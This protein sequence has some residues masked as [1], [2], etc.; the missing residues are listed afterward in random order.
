MLLSGCPGNKEQ[1]QKQRREAS[2]RQAAET[3]ED[4]LPGRF[5]RIIDP[6]S[7][8]TSHLLATFHLLCRQQLNLPPSVYD[9]LGRADKLVLEYDLSAPDLTR[10][11]DAVMHMPGGR[12]LKNQLP[13]EDYQELILFFRDSLR[14]KLRDIST[15]KPVFLNAMMAGAY[16]ECETPVAM[17]YLLMDTARKQEL[18]VAS[19]ESLEERIGFYDSLSYPKQLQWL[20]YKARHPRQMVDLYQLLQRRYQEGRLDPLY[21]ITD[22]YSDSIPGFMHFTI[23]RRNELWMDRLGKMLEEDAA[24]FVAVGAEHIGGPLGL[25]R[26]LEAAGYRMERIALSSSKQKPAS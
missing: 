4:D 7:G 2:W 14:T 17:D 23:T 12:N 13:T 3:Q 10:R 5:F 21:R 8:D 26:K 16:L 19:L 11:L 24:L 18:P 25:L 9:A 15:I 20:A 22:V 1:S 6:K